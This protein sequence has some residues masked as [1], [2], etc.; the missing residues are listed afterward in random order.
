METIGYAVVEL[1]TGDIVESYP[2][3]MPSV[4]FVLDDTI[5]YFDSPGQVMPSADEPTHMFV[6]RVS[7]AAPPGKVLD[8]QTE[9]FD[10]TNVVVTRTWS[11]PVPTVEV[12]ESVTPYQARIALLEAGL[13]DQLTDLMNDPSTPTAAKIAWEYA[14]VWMRNSVFITSLGPS[15]GL[16]EADIDNLFIAAA[17]VE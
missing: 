13:L 2:L 7:E 11:D 4:R 15:L 17:Q 8:S 6:A 1:A 9:E 14:T 10:G 16:S 3:S 5:T 12:P